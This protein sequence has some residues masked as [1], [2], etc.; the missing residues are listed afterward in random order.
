MS[1]AGKGDNEGLKKGT[2]NFLDSG[3]MHCL[4]C[5]DGLSKFKKLYTRN[6]CHLW[7]I[8]YTYNKVIF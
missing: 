6:M 7:H 5:M 8:S 3:Y 4:G 1:V 2:E